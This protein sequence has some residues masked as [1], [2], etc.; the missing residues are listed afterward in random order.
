[1]PLAGPAA[2]AKNSA[3]DFESREMSEHADLLR[4]RAER[5][6]GESATASACLSQRLSTSQR[7][8]ARL[9]LRLR[10]TEEDIVRLGAARREAAAQAEA[11]RQALERSRDKLVVLARAHRALEAD[12]QASSAREASLARRAKE[13]EASHTEALHAARS[14]ASAFERQWREAEVRLAGAAKCIEELQVRAA[15]A[16]DL[17][18]GETDRADRA[19]AVAAQAQ[20]QGRAMRAEAEAGRNRI[21]ALEA[22]L[23]A[24]DWQRVEA[25]GAAKAREAA[26]LDQA[27]RAQAE[28]LWA[29]EQA[30]QLREQRDEALAAEARASAMLRLRDQA[31]LEQ[32]EAAAAAAALLDE[33]AERTVELE[34]ALAARD[35]ELR[36]FRVQMQR[37]AEIGVQI[38][39]IQALVCQL[40]APEAET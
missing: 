8:V 24:A 21:E 36:R 14:E 9:S 16:V 34:A 15:E 3:N 22:E 2:I 28:L 32:A 40:G 7:E 35:R 37:A 1:M 38:E 31:A 33:R 6:A 25:E 17:G 4:R 30:Q 11:R 23:E 20:A 18:R 27:Q 13:T 5:Q 39:S 29:A 19:E 26:L 10:D 12:F